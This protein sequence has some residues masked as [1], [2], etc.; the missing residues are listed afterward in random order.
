MPGDRAAGKEVIP[1]SGREG[2]K[3]RPG[4]QGQGQ[5]GSWEGGRESERPGGG[6]K[7]ANLKQAGEKLKDTG[8]E[9][10]GAE[11]MDVTQTFIA[12]SAAADEAA[13]PHAGH[14]GVL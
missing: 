4:S 12:T 3:H 5:T 13:R 6:G 2:R 7:K 14:T 8:K 10:T 11:A 9:V 1:L